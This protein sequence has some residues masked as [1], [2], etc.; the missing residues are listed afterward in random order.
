[1]LE[2]AEKYFG[3]SLTTE[4]EGVEKIFD[5]EKNEFLF[6]SESLFPVMERVREFT[7]GELYDVVCQQL[8]LK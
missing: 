1:M 8:L 6:S 2:F 7:V 3:I 5:L 4:E